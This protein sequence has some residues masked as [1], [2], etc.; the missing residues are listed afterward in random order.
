VYYW[1]DSQTVIKY[2]NNDTARFQTFVA[3]RI[4]LIRDGSQPNQWNYVETH[5]N[6]ADDCS[7]GV[8]A[9]NLINSKRWTRGPE[10]LYKSKYQ[11]PK[12]TIKHTTEDMSND[13]EIKRKCTVNAILTEE[14]A[15]TMEKLLSYLSSW[16]KLR[17]AVAWIIKIQDQEVPIPQ[18]KAK[19]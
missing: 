5:D 18:D 13:P 6:P 19:A 3:N 14:S 10:F 11:W 7:R 12:T 2:I 1:T 17:R 4:A 9:D 16:Y 15:E 8:K